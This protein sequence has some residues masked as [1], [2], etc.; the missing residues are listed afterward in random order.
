[1][2]QI[3]FT[4]PKL[5]KASNGW[6]IGFTITNTLTGQKKEIQSRRGLNYLKKKEQK[7]RHAHALVQWWKER[8]ENGWTPEEWLIDIP[9]DSLIF[10][11]TKFIDALD[12]ALD[13]CVV[14]SK[15]KSGYKGSVKFFKQA[16]TALNLNMAIKDIDR[17]HIMLMLKWIREKRKW[18][19]HAYNK[20]LGYI[21][22]VIGR[23]LDWKVIKYNPAENIKTLPVAETR[24]FV[25]YTEEE[26]KAIQ[27]YLFANHYRFF[28]YLLTIYHTGMRPK[29][30]LAIKIKD[31][32]LNNA[33]IT[34]LPDLQAENSKTKNIR[35][36]P[37][38]NHLMM[39]FREFELE[40]YQQEYYLFGSPYES[41]KGNR[42]SSKQGNGAK[43]PDYFKPSPV[44]VKR[45]TVTK[46]WKEIVID[47]LKIKKHL[48]AMKHTG[49]DAKILAGIDLDTLKELYGHSSKFMT[50][51]YVS[52]LLEVHKKTIIEKSPEF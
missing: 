19:N 5:Y 49:A 50:Q 24:K 46:L 35:Y 36:V 34:I 44:Q 20:H 12:F 15:T 22:A 28:V 6:Y 30:V 37:I 51:K 11:V 16:A 38:N 8:L 21:C 2:N 18:S 14:A 13:N 33:M 4:E 45:D 7:L 17:P 39:F 29:E 31:I 23:L 43:H 10:P 42:G 26:K 1:M 41:G 3:I 27:D 25:P 52:V 47:K 48:Y 9:K 32:D 40:Q